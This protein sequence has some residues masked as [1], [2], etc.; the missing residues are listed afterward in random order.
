MTTTTTTTK[1]KQTLNK[2]E[3]Y[4]LIC[5]FMGITCEKQETLNKLAHLKSE[6]RKGFDSPLTCPIN[7]FGTNLFIFSY[8]IY[9]DMYRTLIQPKITL[10]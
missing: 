8:E 6:I 1:N 5:D 4:C 2:V 9:A 7:I 3:V 10:C